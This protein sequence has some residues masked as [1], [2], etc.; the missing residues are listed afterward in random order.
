MH[1]AT[2]LEYRHIGALRVRGVLRGTNRPIGRQIFLPPNIRY[3]CC[4]DE[5][6]LELKIALFGIGTKICSVSR[7]RSSKHSMKRIGEGSKGHD[8]GHLACVHPKTKMSVP[9]VEIRVAGSWPVLRHTPRGRERKSYPRCECSSQIGG[10][11]SDGQFN[12]R[13]WLHELLARNT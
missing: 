6:H 12:A 8:P 4:F 3:H 10:R 2:E 9:P 7:V 5:I 13:H 1:W 11:E